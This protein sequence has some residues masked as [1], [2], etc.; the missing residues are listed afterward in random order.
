MSDIT[1]KLTSPHMTG[2]VVSRFQ[3]DINDELARWDVPFALDVDGDYGM[4]TRDTALSVCYGLGLDNEIMDGGATPEVRLKIRNRLL[5]PTEQLRYNARADWRVRLAERYRTP[6]DAIRVAISYARSKVGV[7]EN[8][9]GSNR[10]LQIDKW[11]QDCNFLGGPWCGAFANACLV[12]AGFPTQWWLRYCPYTEQRSKTG[13]GGWSWRT[14]ANLGDLVLYGRTE[15][16]HVGLVTSL[17]GAGRVDDETIEGN[18]TTGP[19]GSQSNGGIVAVRHRHT[20]GS[21][22][23][24]FPIRGYARPPWAEVS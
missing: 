10:G 14:N 4:L 23:A 1:L 11:E 12:A 8:P 9:A 7:T 19:G 13:E 3:G 2:S 17:D 16:V 6:D 5:T 24:S 21:L 18:T 22:A 15:A 20:D